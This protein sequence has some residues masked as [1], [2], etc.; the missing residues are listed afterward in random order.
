MINLIY[1]QFTWRSK[2]KAYLLRKRTIL[3]QS[4]YWQYQNLSL[5]ILNIFALKDFLGGHSSDVTKADF[6]AFIKKAAVKGTPEYNELY[7]FLLSC[8]QAGDAHKVKNYF[9]RAITYLWQIERAEA[10][11]KKQIKM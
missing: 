4:T 3:T 8:F 5:N 11:Y 6:T 10:E 1:I 7:F 2:I 9:M